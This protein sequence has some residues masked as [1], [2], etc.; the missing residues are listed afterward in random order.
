MHQVDDEWHM[1]YECSALASLRA[2]HRGLFGHDVG[3]DVR[4]FMEQEDQRS[5]FRFVIGCMRIVV[6]A[7]R[8][9]DF[10]SVVPVVD[11]GFAGMPEASDTFDSDSD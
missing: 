1:I 2:A 8:T 9:V 4:A 6:H 11:M 7:A 3:H 5:L 10:V